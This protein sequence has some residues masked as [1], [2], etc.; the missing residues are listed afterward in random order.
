MARRSMA[1]G[2]CR[3]KD[4]LT[5]ED[6]NEARR[7]RKCQK[8]EPISFPWI[9][10]CIICKPVSSRTCWLSPLGLTEGCPFVL[11]VAASHDSAVEDERGH[12][13]TPPL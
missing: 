9:G 13:L 4:Q 10:G 6:G 3:K 5:V 2:R 8:K 7:E 11:P 12:A 1:V